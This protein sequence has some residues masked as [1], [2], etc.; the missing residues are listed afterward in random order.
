M[1]IRKRTLKGS[2]PFAQE[3][4]IRDKK[5]R[6]GPGIKGRIQPTIPARDKNNPVIISSSVTVL[7]YGVEC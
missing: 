3:R 2:H 5:L 6:G 4:T 7:P 1:M